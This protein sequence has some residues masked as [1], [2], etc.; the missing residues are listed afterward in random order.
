MKAKR[1]S[2]P[3]PFSTKWTK[4]IGDLLATFHAA[5]KPHCITPTLEAV[6]VLNDFHNCIVDRRAVD[7]AD[8]GAFAARYAENAWRLAVVVHAAQWA[9]EAGN[10]P[11]LPKPPPTPSGSSSGSPR[12]NWIFSPK[13]VAPLLPRWRMKSLNCSKPTASAKARTS[14]RRAKS[15]APVS[16]PADAAKAL[17]AR[18]EAEGQLVA[19]DITP[20]HGGKT[21]RIY[22]AV[23]NP[24]PG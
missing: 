22:R 23:K 7:L 2:S 21:T 24:V 5:D 10:E 18:M 14:S 13:A 8:V 15:T 1:K 19:E 9:G 4:L 3:S 12:R 20:A 16:S 6:A 11:C 17:L